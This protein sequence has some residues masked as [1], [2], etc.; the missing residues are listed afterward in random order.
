[1]MT[2]SDKPFWEQTYTDDTL[3]TFGTQPNQEIADMWPTFPPGASILEAGCGEGKNALFLAEKGFDV[4]A[5]DI[6]A[7]GIAKVNR[8]AAARGVTLNAWVQDLVTYPFERTYDVILTYG[9]LHFVEKAGWQAFLRR[10]KAHTPSGGL[11]IVQIF[12]NKVPASPDIAPFAIGLANEGEL[13]EIYQDWEIVRST[14]YVFDDE[15]PGVPP[16][17][18]ASNKVV[19]QKP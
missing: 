18:H 6:S 10:A 1:M 17:Q 13:Q 3:T 7:A 15:H 4:H 2:K 11:H 16:H 19:A 9:T 5:I 12:T 8:S 14:A